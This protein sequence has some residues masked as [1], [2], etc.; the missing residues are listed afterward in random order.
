MLVVIRT[1]KDR[2]LQTLIEVCTDFATLHRLAEQVF[3]MEEDDESEDMM[4]MMDRSQ[5]TGR[6]VSEPT[7]SPSLQQMFARARW[8]GYEMRPI[9]RH[10][11]NTRRPLEPPRAPGQGYRTPFRPGRDYSKIKCFTWGN[12]RRTQARCPKPDSTLPFKPDGWNVQSDFPRQR[13]NSS[14]QGNEI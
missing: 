14:P 2:K 11:E 5:W 13:I 6:G 1:Q 4:A 8:M 10:E 3:A 7:M 12:M 9:A